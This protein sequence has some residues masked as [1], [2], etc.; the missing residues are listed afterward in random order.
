[1]HRRALVEA[2]ETLREPTDANE[3]QLRERL[4]ELVDPEGAD[5]VGCEEALVAARRCLWR[6]CLLRFLEEC[7][8]TES[9]AVRVADDRL[10]RCKSAADFRAMW[11]GL[12]AEYR[13]PAPPPP[14]RSSCGKVL[15][16]APGFG[17]NATPEQLQKLMD[18]FPAAIVTSNQHANPEESGFDMSKRIKRILQEIDEHKPKAILCASKGG[19]YMEEL[20]RLM[21]AGGHDH[22]K[23]IG[24]LMINARLGLTSLPSGVKVIV[25]QG[26]NEKKWPR[27]RGYDMHGKVEDGS[28]EALI[29]T[30]SPGMC[31]LYYTADVESGFGN[32]EGD[33]HVPAS[34][35]EY[36]CLPRLVDTL[37]SSSPGSLG[38]I[39]QASSRKFVSAERRDAENRL[40]WH[41]DALRSRFV[42]RERRADVP[43]DSEEF[44]NVE[45]IFKANPTEG[46]ER[47]YFSDRG[48]DHLD[49]TKIERVQNRQLKDSVDNT[50][51][52]L[53]E[54]LES[55]DE[56]YQAGVHSRWL[57]HG[58]GSADALNKITRI[59]S[60][61]S[62]RR[63]RATTARRTSG[64]MAP[65]LRVTPHTAC[66]GTTAKPATMRA[67]AWSCSASS[68]AACRAS[69]RGT[70][71]SCPRRTSSRGIASCPTCRSSTTPPTP[72]SSWSTA[73]RPT[74]R[75][76]FTSVRGSRDFG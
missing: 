73:S 66:T 65:T 1:M 33:M 74:P 38:S 37:L 40:G 2:L 63:R 49:I 12:V 27:P 56:K 17:F 7:W 20:W 58:A 36:D 64:A 31:Y 21:E 41:P 30:G 72:R 11:A 35:L 76:S 51:G 19:R 9:D 69:A 47:F 6:R 13:P 28:L 4:L 71:A 14:G 39:F 48:T 68:S 60:A 43:K 57:F 32:R 5:P 54:L 26:A 44:K 67:N 34:L 24:Y 50:R 23:G 62:V 45:T 46:V 52:R 53:K 16:I 55:F 25:V 18:T 29:R 10:K 8:R 61:A 59:P 3:H 70:C 22:L 42:G 75:T 15:V